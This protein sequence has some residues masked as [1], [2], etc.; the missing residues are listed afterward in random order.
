MLISKWGRLPS[1]TYGGLRLLAVLVLSSRIRPIGH[2]A[3]L[4]SVPA[5]GRRKKQLHL[6]NSEAHVI[7]NVILRLRERPISYL[8]LGMVMAV[9]AVIVISC[10]GNISTMLGP[11]MGTVKVSISDPPSCMPPNG[12]FTH[13]W[14]TVRSVQAHTSACWRNSAR[15][16]CLRGAFNRSA[17][18]YF[19]IV[20]RREWRCLLRMRA[21]GTDLTALSW[22]TTA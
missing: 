17:C 12:N 15:R 3:S 14:I 6:S 1:T 13:V 7:S 8:L 11:N 22:R 16:A 5:P 10:G 18:S 19:P 21:R 4:N 2:P 9:V 20:L